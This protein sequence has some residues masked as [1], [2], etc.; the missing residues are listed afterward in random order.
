ML[1]LV[2]GASTPLR[3]VVLQL[4]ESPDL[5]VESLDMLADLARVLGGRGIELRLT[6][7]RA[8]VLEL[9]RRSGVAEQVR[10]EPTVDA[11]VRR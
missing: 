10:V 2:D 4:A 1:E 8:P 6:S 9:L 3:A 5:D 7:V 11:A